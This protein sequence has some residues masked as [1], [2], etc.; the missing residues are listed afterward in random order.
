MLHRADVDI[1]HKKKRNKEIKHKDAEKYQL[2]KNTLN[3]GKG[4]VR[5]HLTR[6]PSSYW[7]V[8][9]AWAWS[10]YITPK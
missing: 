4:S 2:I 10:N 5:T 9:Q 3:S 1:V 7:W 8:A 6:L